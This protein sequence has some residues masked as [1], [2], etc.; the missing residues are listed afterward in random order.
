MIHHHQNEPIVVS[1]EY[2]DTF[3]G[4]ANYCWVKRGEFQDSPG[5][6]DNLIVKKVKAALGLSGV[7]CKRFS[8]GDMIELRP[9]GSATVL[10]INR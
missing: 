5:T 3:A 4:E 1:Y 2:T 8:H 10:F 7:R 9:Y 6:P